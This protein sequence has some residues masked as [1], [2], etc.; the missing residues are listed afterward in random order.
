M[1]VLV[2]PPNNIKPLTSKWLFKNKHDEEN[3]VINNKTRLVVRGYRQEEG[4]DFKESFALVARMEAIG[5]FLAYATHKSFIVFQMNVKTTFLHGSLKEDMC[6]CQHEGFIDADHL[7]HVYKLNK[8][9]Y[10]LK[11]ALRAWYDKLSKF[12]QRNHF[13]KGTINPTM[14]IRCFDNNIL[15]VQDYVD[16]IIFGST[17]P[18]LSQPR[19]IS[20]RLKGSFVTS[21]EPSIWDSGIRR[22]LVLN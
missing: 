18:R 14:F 15:L 4:I 21:E 12:L 16:D 5:I 1:W 19:S 17:N 13:N 3:T 7:S 8:A 11:Q 9:L 22:I 20:R 6:V 10:V 2:P